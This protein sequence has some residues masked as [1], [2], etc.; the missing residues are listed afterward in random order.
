MVEVERAVA[1]QNLLGEGPVWSVRDQKLYWLDIS[2]KTI[3]RFDG[4]SADYETF[5]LERVIGSFAINEDGSLTLATEDGF[6]LWDFH[7]Q[8]MTMLEDNI[9]Y[10]PPGRFNDGKV[11]RKGRFWA[12]TMVDEPVGV[13]YRMNLDGSIHAMESGIKTSNGIG[14]SP[15]NKTM[16]YCDS[17]IATIYAY[18]FD[19]EAGS[20]TNRRVFI[21]FDKEKEGSSDGLTVDSEGCVW[22]ACW[23]GWRVLRIDP[24]GKIMREIRMPVQRPTS[25]S[26]GGTNLD[27]LYVTS[28]G[29]GL[30]KQ[31]QPYAGDV[32]R[33]QTD[34]KGLPEPYAKIRF[35]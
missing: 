15:D 17:G 21:Q 8:R 20:I 12:G 34:V 27:V 22:T 6:A 31:Q 9:A 29:E 26:F 23:D 3:H 4:S 5:S 33:I 11:D 19:L 35:A 25:C 10:D 14:W 30:D 2:G 13:L 32:F 1:S 18:D 24:D 7:K 16:Y 28:A